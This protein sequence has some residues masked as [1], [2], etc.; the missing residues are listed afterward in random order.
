MSQGYP[1]FEDPF[2]GS[3][4]GTLLPLCQRYLFVTNAIV[5][6]S[7]W[8]WLGLSVAQIWIEI[9]DIFISE[10]MYLYQIYVFISGI[11]DS[12]WWAP[13]LVCY[14]AECLSRDWTTVMCA[15]WLPSFLSFCCHPQL[16]S[17]HHQ[18]W[19]PCC[20]RRL[21]CFKINPPCLPHLES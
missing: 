3:L 20:H 13:S 11:W 17:S 8:W 5:H 2:P 4:T 14:A 10:T 12:A 19:F 21:L 9:E 18:K 7:Y 16:G 6:I 15:I 1:N